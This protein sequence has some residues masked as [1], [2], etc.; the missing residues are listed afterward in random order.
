MNINKQHNVP[1]E[2][3][4]N[5]LRKLGVFDQILH[6]L[7][8]IFMAIKQSKGLKTCS[9]FLNKYL[10]YFNFL[11]YV[12]QSSSSALASFTMITETKGK[13][14]KAI[15]ADETEVG[16]NIPVTV[17]NQN[18]LVEFGKGYLLSLIQE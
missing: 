2:W 13:K 7:K 11:E 16:S 15:T 6:S 8:D 12:M 17:L 4:K 1:V 10:R 9:F 14:L 5:E 3:Y 18:Y